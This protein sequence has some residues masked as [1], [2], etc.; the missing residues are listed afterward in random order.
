MLARNAFRRA[1]TPTSK[2][3]LHSGAKLNCSSTAAAVMTSSVKLSI[4]SDARDQALGHGLGYYGNDMAENRNLA[5]GLRSSRPPGSVSLGSTP[6]P[7]P[8][9]DVE[10]SDAE[11]EIRTGRALFVLQETLPEFFKVG[12]VTKVDKLTGAP[13]ITKSSSVLPISLGPGANPMDV[14]HSNGHEGAGHPSESDVE[15][16][17]SPK[18]KLEYTPPTALP[19]PFPRTL[20]IEGLPLYLASASFMRHTMNALYTDLVVTMLKISLDT[21]PRAAPKKDESGGSGLREGPQKKRS[22]REKGLLMRFMVTGNSRVSGSAGEW[23]VESIY[24]FSPVSGLIHK[25][26]INSIHPAPH[27]A[28]Y[29]SLSKVFGFGWSSGGGDVGKGPAPGTMCNGHSK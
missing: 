20:H 13:V 25:Q 29:D 5:L 9:E 21:P 11:W 22:L 18:V 4:P 1:Y 26:I 3:V 2:S 23:E 12:L 17:Y 24:M 27:Q 16:I 6:K 8:K 14:I 19:T 28:V 15:P 10:L 7:D